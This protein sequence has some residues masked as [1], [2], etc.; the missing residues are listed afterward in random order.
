M[1]LGEQVR[2]RI[3]LFKFFDQGR[4]FYLPCPGLLDEAQAQMRR[5]RIGPLS[6]QIII[7]KGNIYRDKIGVRRDIKD[8]VPGIR[9]N[10]VNRRQPYRGKATSRKNGQS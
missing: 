7:G 2:V 8:R 4:G 10:F 3:Q 9:F 6:E 5:S 1:R